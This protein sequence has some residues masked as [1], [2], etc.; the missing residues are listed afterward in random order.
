MHTPPRICIV[1][2]EATPF[3]KTGGLADVSSALARHLARAGADARLVMPM[4]RRVLGVVEDPQPLAHAQDVPVRCGGRT[5]HFSIS[6]ARIPQSSAPVWFVRCPELYDR[7]GI[8]GEGPEEA[9]R[10]ALLCRAAIQTCQWLG[11]APDVF[12]CNDWH[13]ALIPLYLRTVYGWDRMFGNTRTL[14]SIHNI[15]YQ[16]VFG[17]DV[18]EPL[19]LADHRSLLYQEDLAEGRVNLLKTGILYADALSTVSQ[20]YGHEIQT[21]EYGMGLHELLRARSDH[22]VGIVNGV[23]YDEWNP[24]ADPRIAAPFDA[25]DPS[26]KETCRRALLE[27]VELPHGAR[28][29][30]LGVVSRLTAQKGFELLPDVLP[31]FLQRLDLRLVVLGSGDP[32]TEDYFRWLQSQFPGKVAFHNGY[33]ED[34]AHQIEAGSDLFLM[35]SRYEPCG[36]NQMYSLRYGTIPVVRRTGGLADTVIPWNPETREGTGFV[37]ERFDSED[38]YRALERALHAWTDRDAWRVLVDNAMR[39]DWSWEHQVRKYLELY[40]RL[41]QL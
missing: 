7:D 35:P 17:T 31:V 4:Y 29:P 30:V 40:A 18:L 1:A 39:A 5:L 37:F 20:T 41:D 10:F 24:A 22:L 32:R 23:D 38:L 6:T 27:R 28:V 12:H 19:E 36:L 3:A 14:L 11:W 16:G 33:S 15:G 13:A 2:A 25:D 8:Y 34:L 21:E 9:L 26:G